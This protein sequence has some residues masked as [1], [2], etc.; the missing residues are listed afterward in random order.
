M[1]MLK[2]GRAYPADIILFQLSI[3]LFG[4]FIE[5]KRHSVNPNVQNEHPGADLSSYH[6]NRFTCTSV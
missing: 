6:G 2:I 4:K 5:Y 3:K 1:I